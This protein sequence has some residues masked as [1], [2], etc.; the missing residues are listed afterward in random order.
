MLTNR[1]LTPEF[2]KLIYHFPCPYD[3]LLPPATDKN[4]T[5]TTDKP[6]SDVQT[7]PEQSEQKLEPKKDIIFQMQLL[8]ARM[9]MSNVGSVSTSGLTTSFGWD[10][11]VILINNS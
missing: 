8:F 11:Y 7:N 9:Q 3:K 4:S 1:Y 6:M 5:I 2:R 10:K